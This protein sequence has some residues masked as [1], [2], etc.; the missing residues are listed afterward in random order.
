M[1]KRLYSDTECFAILDEFRAKNFHLYSDPNFTGVSVRLDDDGDVR[2]ATYSSSGTLNFSP[3]SRLSYLFEGL[4]Q[5]IEVLNEQRDSLYALQGGFEDGSPVGD[6]QSKYGGTGGWSFFLDLGGGFMPLV[7]ISNWHV[8]CQVNGNNTQ[9]GIPIGL[10]GFNASLFAF[11]NVEENRLND[12]D[13]ALA[14][15]EKNDDCAKQ[16]RVCNDGKRYPH[17]KTLSTNVALNDG[18]TYHKV[19]NGN[20]GIV[21]DQ[22]Q[23][24]EFGDYQA[25]TSIG[26]DIGIKK[27]YL[28]KNQLLFDDISTPGDSGSVIVRNSDNTVTGL[29]SA[30]PPG[31]GTNQRLMANPLYSRPWKPK[32]FVSSEGLTLPIFE[33]PDIAELVTQQAARNFNIAAS[34]FANP[35]SNLELLSARQRSVLIGFAKASG[36]GF[37]QAI[38]YGRNTVGAYTWVDSP[39]PN[40]VGAENDIT[41]VLVQCKTD[42][43][44]NRE[45]DPSGI[46]D[47]IYAVFEPIG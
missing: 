44:A 5:E 37:P 22:G 27:N 24:R 45:N 41:L 6:P 17:P 7:C 32:G 20:S 23:L 30:S 10:N 35:S 40:N 11:N 3:T 34:K 39:P 31:T 33:A 18:A 29:L 1:A 38:I 26:S 36:A 15:Y 12:W 46:Q 8:F 9:I 16:M 25:S 2:L 13:F 4:Q 47:C 43:I 19:G 14:R 28:F 21:C 42:S